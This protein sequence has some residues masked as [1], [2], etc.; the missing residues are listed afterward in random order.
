MSTLMSH[1]SVQDSDVVVL[2]PLYRMRNETN[3]VRLHG[4]QSL[5]A[6][7]IHR[8][9]AVALALCNGERTIGDIAR[10]TRPLA[11]SSDSAEALAT[12]KQYIKSLVQRMLL[13]KE[14]SEGRPKARTTTDYPAD[15]VLL[16]KDIFTQRVLPAGLRPVEYDAR[17]FLPKDSEKENQA[18]VRSYHVNAPVELVWHLTS[19]CSVDCKYCYLKRRPIEPMPKERALELIEEAASLGV[20]GITV[21]GRRRFALS[22][23]K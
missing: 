6:Y 22:S 20:L 4:A 23:P 18:E 9:S 12:A 14:Q 11:A 8:A 7:Q 3:D 1:S 13:T 16:P 21:G 10:I 17:A 15:T 2:N 19:N 5:P